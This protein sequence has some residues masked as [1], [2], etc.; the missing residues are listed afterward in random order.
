MSIRKWVATLV[1]VTLLCY[2]VVQTPPQA[3]AELLTFDFNSGY[4]PN[5]SVRNDGGL[6][7]VGSDGSALRISKPADDGSFN[8]QGQ[9]WGGIKS[10]FS[11]EGDFSVTVDFTLHDFPFPGGEFALAKL[12]ESVLG[13]FPDNGGVFEVLRFRQGTA[14]DLIEAFVAPPG[15]A[16]G[17]PDSSLTTGQYRITRSEST[18]SG[19]YAIAG[20]TEFVSLG[21]YG[22]SLEPVHV[23]LFGVEGMNGGYRSTTSFD[24]GFDNLVIQAD[25]I[26]GTVPEPSTFAMFMGLGGMGLIAAWRRRKRTA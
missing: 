11:L 16:L 19:W 20:S 5:F 25:R 2:C 24:I 3:R 10:I 13:V 1:G 6:W 22:G 26:N 9:I 18:Y 15:I 21:S 14:M 23:Q 7:T 8:G 17:W 12:N 4:G